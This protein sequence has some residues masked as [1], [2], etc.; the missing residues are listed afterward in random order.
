MILGWFKHL[1]AGIGSTKA[2]SH[3]RGG[4]LFDGMARW[5]HDDL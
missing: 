3:T 4:R 2:R 5:G 1:S